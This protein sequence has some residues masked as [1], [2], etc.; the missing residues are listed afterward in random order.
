MEVFARYQLLSKCTITAMSFNPNHSLLA[1]TADGNDTATF[2]MPGAD[3]SLIPKF[4]NESR[5]SSL[6]CIAWSPNGRYI[7]VAGSKIEVWKFE[8]MKL[9]PIGTFQEGFVEIKNLVW[10]PDSK[11]YLCNGINSK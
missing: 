6:A 10:A 8:N 11:S 7:G 2:F 1:L 5:P 3:L 9:S 4:V